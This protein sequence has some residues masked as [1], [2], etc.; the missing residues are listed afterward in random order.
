MQVCKSKAQTSFLSFSLVLRCT[1]MHN[2]GAAFYLEDTKRGNIVKQTERRLA[3]GLKHT[4]GLWE[5][6]LDEYFSS[7]SFLLSSQLQFS[8][9][10]KG[11]YTQTLAHTH[12]YCAHTGTYIQKTW[13]KISNPWVF[14][15]FLFFFLEN[16]LKIIL[17]ISKK[18][19]CTALHYKQL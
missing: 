16:V 18:L 14:F 3:M 12:K 5:T 2:E 17:K 19:H 9:T 8:K 15:L 7:I 13:I 6:E 4:E 11:K 1:N 10:L